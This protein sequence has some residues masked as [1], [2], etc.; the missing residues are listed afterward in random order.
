MR[1]DNIISQKTVSYFL[2]NGMSSLFV[3]CITVGTSAHT[4]FIIQHTWLVGCPTPS[5]VQ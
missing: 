2:I 4:V 3:E 1:T 5:N